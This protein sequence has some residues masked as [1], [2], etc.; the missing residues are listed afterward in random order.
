MSVVKTGKRPLRSLTAHEKLD[1]IRRVHG[2]ETK[3][4]VA[5]DIGVPESTLRGWCKNEDKIAYLSRQS[6]PDTDE[7]FNDY[8]I[9][10]KPKVEDQPFNLS[11]K[12]NG[13]HSPN[14][15]DDLRFKHTE[16]DSSMNTSLYRPQ[17]SQFTNRMTESE[18][19]R[20][21]LARMNSCPSDLTAFTANMMAHWNALVMQKALQEQAKTYVTAAADTSTRISPAECGLLT[22]VDKQKDMVHHLP[23][24]KQRVD[25]AILSWLSTSATLQTSNGIPSSSPA[26]TSTVSSTQFDN[27]MTANQ[28]SCF[29]KRYNQQPYGQQLPQ[30]TKL[31]YYQQL[32]NE[33]Q[34]A[35]LS[36]PV[37]PQPLLQIVRVPDQQGA[38][39]VSMHNEQ[40]KETTNN[41]VRSVLDKLLLNNS[42]NVAVN[43][44]ATRV[45]EDTLTRI[46]AV[47]HGEKFLE[48]LE[49]CSDPSITAMQ[50]IQYRTLL[51]NLKAGEDRKNGELQVKSKVKRK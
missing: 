5:S 39:N 35:T 1:A 26:S 38:E 32:T 4:S 13:Q 20:S 44:N 11:L 47:Q 24:D 43:R 6:S 34:A 41:K 22:T 36:P 49:T 46:E 10:K 25:E 19:S 33:P 31:V 8:T 18:R 16:P 23:K 30:D 51:N 2:G 17:T 27:S 42:I 7:S 15:E 40:Q 37:Q 21:E 48:W 29:L 3:A 50:I 28:S 45:E 12:R 9:S 14:Y